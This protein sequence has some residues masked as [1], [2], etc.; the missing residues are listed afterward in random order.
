MTGYRYQPPSTPAFTTWQAAG[1][2]AV[3]ALWT[4]Y[5]ATK[6]LGSDDIKG[7]LY[8]QF[9]QEIFANYY[10]KCAFC[11]CVIGGLDQPGD[12]EHFRPKLGVQ[13]AQGKPV[14]V[15]MFGVRRSPHPGYFWL[16]YTWDNLIPACALCNREG[17]RNYFPVDPPGSNAKD[18]KELAREVPLL[19]HPG[20]EDPAKHLKLD[21][22]DFLLVATSPRGQTAIDVLKLN[23]TK[24]IE[25]R[26][27]TYMAVKALLKTELDT[28]FL[29]GS[30][31]AVQT[32]WSKQLALHR[33]KKTGYTLAVTAAIEDFDAFLADVIA[34]P[35]RVPALAGVR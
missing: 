5:R 9:K 11:E 30:D 19:I 15:R 35:R 14:M 28:M 31:A 8:K 17:K 22:S 21:R 34:N 33:Q 25:Q 10:D 16:A 32:E 12:V 2:S 7:E 3:A 29:I 27:Q 6:K 24:L 20:L 13:N 23:R 1:Q 18:P 4:K 26:R